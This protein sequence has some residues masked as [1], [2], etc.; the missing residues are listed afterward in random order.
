[1]SKALLA[2]LGVACALALVVAAILV[3]G[4]VGQ[5]LLAGV[6]V[7]P[8]LVLAVLAQLG[9]KRGWARALTY[10]WLTVLVFGFSMLVL[11]LTV[12][13]LASP[14][15]EPRPA[16]QGGVGRTL[17]AILG[18]LALAATL[19]FH[20]VRQRVARYLPIN[21][22]SLVHEVALF[23]IVF[24]VVAS[25]AQ[26]AVLGGQPPLLLS[27]ESLSAEQLTGGR[28][29]GGQIL[30]MLYGLGWTL[31]MAVVAAGYP[32]SRPLRRAIERLGFTRPTRRQV[33]IGLVLAVALVG[34]FSGF[35]QIIGLIWDHFGWPTTN[36]EAF[37][38]LLGAGF[39][40]VGAL[41][42]GVTAGVGEEAAT[43]GL[44]QPRL[45]KVLPNLAFAAAHAFQYGPD[46]LISVF[47][48]GLVLAFVRSRSNTTVAALVHGA[49]D[50]VSIM[51][52]IYGF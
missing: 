31:P 50:F 27:V 26:L 47:L 49:Y 8:F 17:L 28:S 6:E 11:S 41:A 2:A 20:E 4:E 14:G 18:S 45:G 33:L 15:G 39:S 9:E 19:L 10:L 29:S 48:T 37:K 7:G 25:F 21:P 40:P 46:A 38:K 35:D 16:L 52:D 44:L 13:A 51:L 34:V 30:D 23:F 1:M 32:V 42:V 36:E 3:G 12:A 22:D 24:F 43:R 5:F